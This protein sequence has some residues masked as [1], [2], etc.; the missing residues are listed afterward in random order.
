M[1]LY[2]RRLAYPVSLE[3]PPTTSLDVYPLPEDLTPIPL[4]RPLLLLPGIR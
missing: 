1:L 4:C 3:N 2:F